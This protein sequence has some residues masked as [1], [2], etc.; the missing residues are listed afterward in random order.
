MACHS[1]HPRPRLTRE[2]LVRFDHAM[3]QPQA[4]ARCQSCH[5]APAD[6]L[7]RGQNLACA[8]CHNPAGW[9]PASFD[10]ASFFRLDGDHDTACITCH[11][12]GDYSRYTCFGCHAHESQRMI[13]KHREEGITDIRNCVRCHRSGEGEEYEDGRAGEDD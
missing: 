7:H 9:K 12:G 13:A 6:G 8:T 2:R 10:H 1:D 11:T 4:R 5:T 3:L